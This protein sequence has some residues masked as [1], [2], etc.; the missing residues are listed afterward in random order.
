MNRFTREMGSQLLELLE[1]ERGL[2]AQMLEITEK[3][4]GILAEDDTDGFERSLDARQAQIEQ[5]NGL[6]RESDVLVQSYMSR[7]AG[8]DSLLASEIDAV[9]EYI[10]GLLTECAA[11]N[12]RNT[13]TAIE[14]TEDY[15]KQIGKMSLNRK[16]IG[17]YIQE[18]PNNSELF[19]KKT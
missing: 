19:D 9:R 3:Q 18:V 13:E 4:A 1:Q 14:K 8:F 7:P 10:R 12:K 6:H 16:G 17:A 11:L 15:I 5:I 2:L